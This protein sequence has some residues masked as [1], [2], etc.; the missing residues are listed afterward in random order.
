MSFARPSQDQQR[1]RREA[2]RAANLAALCVPSRSLRASVYGGS[3]TPAPKDEPYRDDVLLLMAKDRPCLFLIPGIC[4]H[5]LDTTVAAHENQGK[6]MG[7]K[8]PDNRSVWGCAA[9]HIGWYDQGSAPREHKREA[10]AEAFQRQMRAWRQVAMDAGEPARFRRAAQR[11][12]DELEAR[13]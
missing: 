11:A 6:G 2:Q 10:F 5:R 12:L 3:T 1:A 13:E 9:C 7:I 4:N 8:A